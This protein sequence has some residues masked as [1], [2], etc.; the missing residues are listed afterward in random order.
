M[1][2]GDVLG[3]IIIVFPFGNICYY[4][5]SQQIRQS[6][7]PFLLDYFYTGYNLEFPISGILNKENIT[8]R[9]FME[10]AFVSLVWLAAFL[11][12]VVEA[13]PT[14]VL[15]YT[16]WLRLTQASCFGFHFGLSRL[17]L[18]LLFGDLQLHFVSFRYFLPLCIIF[19]D[20]FLSDMFSI[21]S[22]INSDLFMATFHLFQ[23]NFS[24]ISKRAPT[25]LL[26]CR[27]SNSKLSRLA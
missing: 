6:V 15:A 21:C 26:L 7:G 8:P 18:G 27:R 19:L 22:R 1:L 23:P 17:W 10:A 12:A 13:P 3:A 9:N 2:E 11:S 24:Y 14:L 20:L 25:E 16:G 4:P 5:P